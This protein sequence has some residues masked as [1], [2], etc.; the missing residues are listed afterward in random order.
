VRPLSRSSEG[1]DAGSWGAWLPVIADAMTRLQALPERT[2]ILVP[3]AQLMDAGRRAWARSHPSGF[4]P[5]FESTRN[6]AHALA[7]FSPGPSDLSMDAARDSLVAASLIDRVAQGQL[8]PSLRA[9]MVT[10][11][12]EAARQLAPLAAAT[13]PVQRLAWAESL[14]TTLVP[15]SQALHWESLLASLAL[16]WVSTSAYATDALWGAFAEPGRDADALLVLPGF[17][18]D[19]LTQALA[20]RWGERAA[21]LD[22]VAATRTSHRSGEIRQHPC[23]DAEDE[24]QRAAACIVKHVQAGRGP[25]ALVA[26]DRV[27][28]RRV[29]AMLHGAGLAV[30]DETGWKLSTSHSAAQLMSLLRAAQRRAS[31]DDLLDWL[32]QSPAWSEGQVVELE[33][34]A[35][36][37]G[38]ASWRSALQPRSSAPDLVPELAL[39]LEGLQAPRPLVQWL[40]DLNSAL[41]AC[42]LWDVWQSDLAGQQMIQALRL[43]DGAAWE[44]DPLS[45]ISVSDDAFEVAAPRRSG[46]RMSPPAFSAWVREVLEGA[47]FMPRSVGDAEVV[48]LPMAQ[49]L[50]RDFLAVVAPGCDEIH[51]N[52][53]PEPPGQWTVAQRELLGLPTRESLAAALA[54][55]WEVALDQQQLDI[56]W[57]GQDR[58]ESLLASPWVQALPDF[59]AIAADPRGQRSLEVQVPSRPEPVAGDLLP[60]SLSASAYQDL[61]DCPYRFFALRQLKLSEAPELETEPDA[62]DMG[63]WLHLVLRR[64]HEQRGD[65]RPG[66]EPDR[67]LLDHFAE[68]TAADMGLNGDEG[69]ARFLPYQAVWPRLRDGYLDWLYGFEASVG[70]PGPHFER[71][72]VAM[73][74]R[75]GDWRLYGKLDRVDRQNSP[76]GPIP[77]VIDYKTENR[78]K[79]LERVKQPLEDTQLAFYAALLPE[80]NLRAAYLS[81]T[82]KRG[83]GPKDAPALLVEQVDVLAAREHLR[84]GLAHDMARVAAGAPMPALGEGRVCDFCAARGLCRKDHWVQ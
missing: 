11:L 14:R 76:E 46:A 23:A 71:A 72:E 58:G 9:V 70:Q 30:R 47:S 42:G 60:E 40:A 84:Q 39:L 63:N 80:E 38:V 64:F 20:L 29:S 4:S 59:G 33:Q 54:L 17:Q 1:G 6:W 53:N 21:V 79:T 25:V 22:T 7:P 16:A 74:A 48:V 81:I 24:A 61:R 52:P 12:V 45:Q 66:W 78:Q 57:R 15:A 10:R 32:K 19:P 83:D 5:R 2:L 36:E 75:A 18:P 65:Q 41:K 35:R 56:L 13:A 62:R 27:L 50:G 8:D 26:N 67:A 49:L 37:Q 55:A 73:N 82:D 68:S 51:L 69:G 31:M 34:W 43:G 44:L 3:Y 28:T 77:F